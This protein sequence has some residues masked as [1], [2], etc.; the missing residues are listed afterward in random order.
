MIKRLDGLGESELRNYLVEGI[1]QRVHS[2]L[3]T[4]DDL[5]GYSANLSDDD[6]VTDEEEETDID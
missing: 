3:G 5:P 4:V 6:S 1:E 2:V